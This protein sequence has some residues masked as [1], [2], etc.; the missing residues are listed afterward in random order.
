MLLLA[1]TMFPMFFFLSLYMQQVLGYSAI[2]AGLAFLVIAGGLVLSSGLAQ[3]LVTKVG[4]KL[5]LTVGLLG[6]AIAQVLFIYLPAAGSFAADLLPGYVIVAAALG[7]AFVGGVIAST[8]GVKP[9]DSG[10]ASGLINTSQQIGGAVGLAVT[11]TVAVNRTNALLHTG[12]PAAAALTGG[13]HGAFAVTGALAVAGALVAVTLVRRA[14]A[15]GPAVSA[16]LT[17]AAQTVST[18]DN[19]VN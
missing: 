14:P 1:G 10:L 9:A 11:T 15:A 19:N 4:A 18:G 2:K 13:F 3:G 7:L 12:H 17:T 6:S 16:D 8:I 5:V